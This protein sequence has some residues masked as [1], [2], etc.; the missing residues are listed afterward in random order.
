MLHN[1]GVLYTNACVAG[2]R[3]HGSVVVNDSTQ[4]RRK[5]FWIVGASTNESLKCY[6][7]LA[8]RLLSVAQHWLV[9][10]H[11]QFTLADPGLNATLISR[12]L[13][14][15]VSVPDCFW[16]QPCPNDLSYRE[17]GLRH[18]RLIL[19]R[20]HHGSQQVT[21]GSHIAIDFANHIATP[22]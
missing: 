9:Y 17:V 5:H 16:Q 6:L 19:Y 18:V 4:A 14:V 3:A 20:S 13:T 1:G 10:L 2:I 12:P 8:V 22:L 11:E 21:F 15:R 7:Y